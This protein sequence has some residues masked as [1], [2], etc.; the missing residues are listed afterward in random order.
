MECPRC[1]NVIGEDDTICQH[2]SL[3]WPGHNDYGK[4]VIVLSLVVSSPKVV[5]SVISSDS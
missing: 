5:K 4:M 1:H 2:C 3:F